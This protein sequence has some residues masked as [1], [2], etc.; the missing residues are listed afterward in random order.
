MAYDEQ[1]AQRIRAILK[2]VPGLVE[3]KGTASLHLVAGL[4]P[5]HSIP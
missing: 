1:L 4:S 2:D 3:K 5:L